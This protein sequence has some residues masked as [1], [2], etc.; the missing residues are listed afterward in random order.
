MINVGLS[1]PP[2]LVTYDF[3]SDLNYVA[4]LRLVQLKF[5]GWVGNLSGKGNLRTGLY[6]AVLDFKSVCNPKNTLF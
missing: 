2:E 5:L 6:I 4:A 1:T 3:R